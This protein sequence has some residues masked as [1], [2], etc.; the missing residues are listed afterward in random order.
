[1]TR[2]AVRRLA[3]RAGPGVAAGGAVAVAVAGISV[4]IARRRAGADRAVSAEGWGRQVRVGAVGARSAARYLAMRVRRLTVAAQQGEQL[5]RAFELRTAQDVAATLGE[6]KGALMKIGQMA[7]Y[8]DQGLPEPVRDALAQLQTDAPPMSAELAAGVIAA[9]LGAPPETVFAS[10]DPEP[11]AAASIGQVHRAVTHDG[12]EA[13]VKVQYPGVREAITADLGS[14]GLIF[15][16]LGLLY[17]G[18]EPEPLIAEI[19]ERLVEELDYEI[20]ATNQRLFCAEYRGHPFIHVPEVFDELS[21]GRVLTTE[22]VRGSRLADVETWDEVERDRVGEIL[23]R[24]VFGSLYR[25]FA[26]NGDPHP[27]NYLVRDDGR[28]SFLDFGMVKHFTGP[29]MEVFNTMLKSM[30]IDRDV[31]AFRAELER[32]GLLPA[33]LDIDDPAIEDY[34]GHFYELVLDDAPLTVTREYASESVRRIFAPSSGHGEIMRAANLPPSFVVIQ[35]INLG[36]YAVLGELGATA[37][38][39]RIAEELWAFTLAPPSTELGRQDA[40]WRARRTGE[41][42]RV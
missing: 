12:R 41:S 26:F 6:L 33:G 10:W 22:L 40:G 7:S 15:S 24:F 36:L 3:S 20:E 32:I 29:E 27:G 42:D 8:L 5:E 18:L 16:G 35:R 13:A 19:R 38:W 39:R 4:A 11:L 31:P 2:S 34:F 28:V 25:F 1:M 14:A 17:P 23:Y 30:V 37:N 9:E 21:T